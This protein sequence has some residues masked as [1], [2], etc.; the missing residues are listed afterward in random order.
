M[1]TT[2]PLY[3]ARDRGSEPLK[4][5]AAK[6]VRVFMSAVLGVVVEMG[7][8]DPGFAGGSR[9]AQA[10]RAR[11]SSGTARRGR[12]MRRGRSG[13]EAGSPARGTNEP[14]QPA[15]DRKDLAVQLR[16]RS[17]CASSANAST[18]T[19]RLIGLTR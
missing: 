4:G 9:S 12:L 15:Q 8:V 10:E 17:P 6:S 3:A 18:R 1:R 14:G 11:A 19:C 5:T 13:V 2:S 16:L 7:E